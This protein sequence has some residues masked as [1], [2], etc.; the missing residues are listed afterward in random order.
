MVRQLARHKVLT[1]YIPENFYSTLDD[2]DK[3]IKLEPNINVEDV[4]Q[5]KKAEQIRS[6]GIRYVLGKYVAQMKKKIIE[7]EAKKNETNQ[8]PNT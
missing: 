5:V 8:N 3:I 4:N 2:F 6:V 7:A 1:V